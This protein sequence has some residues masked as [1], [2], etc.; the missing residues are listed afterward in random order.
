MCS[1]SPISPGS[2]WRGRTCTS[3]ARQ[4]DPQSE[5]DKRERLATI[6]SRCSARNAH[7][8]VANDRV[9]PLLPFVWAE[10]RLWL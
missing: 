8:D 5:R 2:Q 9:Y 10:P 7:N 6:P 3:H 4:L 1:C